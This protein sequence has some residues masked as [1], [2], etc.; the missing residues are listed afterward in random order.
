LFRALSLV[1]F[2]CGH[3]FDLSAGV[4]AA[5]RLVPGIVDLYPFEWQQSY[6]TIEFVKAECTRLAFQLKQ[7]EAAVEL[8]ETKGGSA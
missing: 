2:D 5:L 6:R 8:V 1:R 3:A 7:L 4:N